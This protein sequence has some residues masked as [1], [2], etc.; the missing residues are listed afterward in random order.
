[1]A[2]S[3]VYVILAGATG[4]HSSSGKDI[5]FL[6]KI[7]DFFSYSYIKMSY[8]S[9]SGRKSR[10]YGRRPLS[11]S[12]TSPFSRTSTTYGSL[13]SRRPSSGASGSSGSSG[14]YGSSYGSS[15]SSASYGSSARPSTLGQRPF[16]GGSTRRPSSLGL[17]RRPS[18]L[19]QRRPMS[20]RLSRNTPATKTS[21]SIG[22]QVAS[23]WES[24]KSALGL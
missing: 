10:G 8:K 12:S 3:C 6:C 5:I 2:S 11:G 15:G 7:G 24:V 20:R 1:M 19:G 16:L 14:P 17:S 21:T 4:T 9:S 18:Q 13:A 22:D 23:G